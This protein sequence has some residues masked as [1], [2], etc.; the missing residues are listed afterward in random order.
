[1]PSYKRIDVTEQQL[2]DLLRQYPGEIED[3]LTYVDHQQTT[4]A[5]ADSTSSLLTAEGHWS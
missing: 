3:G 2:E 4:S 5:G 1:M